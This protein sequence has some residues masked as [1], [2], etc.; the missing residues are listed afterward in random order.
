MTEE[1][2][3]LR[4]SALN[5]RSGCL[6]I[7]TPDFQKLCKYFPLRTWCPICVLLISDVLCCCRTCCFRYCDNCCAHTTVSFTHKAFKVYLCNLTEAFFLP[8]NWIDDIF[9][10]S[11]CV[12][13]QTSV[14]LQQ[15][16][17]KSPFCYNKSTIKVRFVTTNLPFLT[18]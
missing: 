18:N 7:G 3:A 8:Q 6:A 11:Y 1:L 9:A 10:S 4:S 15:I 5:V 16:Y 2:N 17:H 14:L 13:R 12:S